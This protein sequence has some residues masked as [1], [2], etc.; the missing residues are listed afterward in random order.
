M[1]WIDRAIG[2]VSTLVL[3]R[4][5]VPDDFGIVAMASLVVAFVD[6]VFD[7][8]VNVALV[9]R[10][11][12]SQAYYNTAWTMRILQ[13]C[14]V[15]TL[16]AVVAPF[17]ADY[18]RDPRVTAAIWMMASSVLILACEN[19]GIVSFQKE[20]NFAAEARFLLFKRLVGFTVT[21]V[22]TLILRDYWGMLFGALCGRLI[23]TLRSYQVHPMRP[24]F[25]LSEFRDIFSISVWLMVKNIS[26]YLDRNLHV[27][28]VGGVSKT[29]VTGG[30]TLANEVSDIPG[31]DLL[32]PINRVLFPVFVRA[33]DD[34]RE[35]TRLLVQAQSVQVAIVFP[36]C[37]GFVM[38][39]ADVVPLALGA[40]WTFIVPFIQVLAL[41]NIILSINSSAN[42]VLTV[43][44]KVRLLAVS[45]WTQI[46]VFC[47]GLLLFHSQLEAQLVA[48]I[49]LVAIVLT[50][51]VSF[52]ILLKH[53]PTMSVG[54]LLKGVARPT[55]GCAAM[56]LALSATGRLALPP[57]PM[58]ALKVAVGGVVYC[59]VVWLL[60]LAVGR[61]EGAESYVLS[62]IRRR[63]PH[64]AAAATGKAGGAAAD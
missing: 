14:C 1:R 17:A 26:Q 42:Y 64:A 36:I 44:G 33:R 3:A 13:A 9:Q 47:I 39:A 11:N 25:A 22:L 52:Y 10:K 50:F 55:L 2:V 23:G 18:Y 57:W 53:L 61:P 51:G 63:K 41:S 46:G 49:R 28:V 43:I 31:T 7:I 5:L 32:A 40:K 48:Q 30:Y 21:I 56:A 60:W 19:I 20:L 29:A 27:V 62:K 35:L 12:P 38:T 4:L 24:R 37:I 6:T 54:L 15:A 8:G 59:G 34:L 16:L 58:L 45:S